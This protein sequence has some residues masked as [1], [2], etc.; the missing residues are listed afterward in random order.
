M[1]KNLCIHIA[2]LL[3]D[4][5]GCGDWGAHHKV[6]KIQ[7]DVANIGATFANLN[8]YIFTPLLILVRISHLESAGG[9]GP[10][11]GEVGVVEICCGATAQ[12]PGAANSE[13]TGTAAR[14]GAP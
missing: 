8:H 13:P 10:G 11:A 6:V 12:T 4:L 3:C 2:D 1:L 7:A 14:V 5:I 9:A